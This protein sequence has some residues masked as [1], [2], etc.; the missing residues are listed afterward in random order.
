[1]LKEFSK[2]KM[3][4]FF[5]IILGLIC[6]IDMPTHAN[7]IAIIHIS[8]SLIADE[9]TVYAIYNEPI[10]KSTVLA[11]DAN[12]GKLR[13]I[14]RFGAEPFKHTI[15]VSKTMLC[16][17]AAYGG[18]Y[19]FEP[20]NGKLVGYIHIKPEKMYSEDC[21]IA[22][23]N[24]Y[25]VVRTDNEIMG[26]KRLGFR[27]IWKKKLIP[28]RAYSIDIRNNNCEIIY[29]ENNNIKKDI[30]NMKNGNNISKSVIKNLYPKA[31]LNKYATHIISTSNMVSPGMRKW[32]VKKLSENKA[33]LN[34]N[35]ITIGDIVCIGIVNNKE[36]DSNSNRIY[37]LNND[38]SKIIWS[39]KIPE[40]VEITKYKNQ[41]L[42]LSVIKKGLFVDG[43][44]SLNNRCKLLMLDTV[45][46][47]K[48]WETPMY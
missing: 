11:C 19:I 7:T 25:I 16:T 35:I 13:W 30:Y 40:L 17:L 1:M 47:K 46:G 41:L 20:Q 5:S 32:Q 48:C 22:C 44:V 27:C 36:L 9:N 21:L 29:L 15:A 24:N 43:R 37:A 3:S 26:F 31:F 6:V 12:S 23:N 42:T 8:N 10:Y 38:A 2:Y 28:E 33:L 14:R 18:V 4:L 34:T 39:K 45:S